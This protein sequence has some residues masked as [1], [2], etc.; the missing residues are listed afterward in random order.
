[1]TA[2]AVNE[3][4]PATTCAYERCQAGGVILAG[5]PAFTRVGLVTGVQLAEYHPGCWA[6]LRHEWA[7]GT[8]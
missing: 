1:M 3:H 4:L 5:A 8:A 6:A 2:R 7:K